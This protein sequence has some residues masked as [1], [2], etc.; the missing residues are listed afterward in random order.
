VSTFNA[1][2]LPETPCHGSGAA[3]ELLDD[4]V[5]VIVVKR[6]QPALSRAKSG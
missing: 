1:G 2:N 5:T 3:Q 6:R 4:D